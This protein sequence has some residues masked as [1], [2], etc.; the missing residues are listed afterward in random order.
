MIS[1]SRIYIFFF[2]L[3][4]IKIIGVLIYFKLLIQKFNVNGVKTPQISLYFAYMFFTSS[5]VSFILLTYVF[6]SQKIQMYI[7][8]VIVEGNLVLISIGLLPFVQRR[9]SSLLLIFPMFIKY[10]M[11]L[12]IFRNDIKAARYVEAQKYG[13]NILAQRALK[14]SLN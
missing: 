3:Y 7:P 4:F 13:L 8:Y 9:Y 14:V 10:F 5:F 11:I 12:Y 6:I 1:N 2:F